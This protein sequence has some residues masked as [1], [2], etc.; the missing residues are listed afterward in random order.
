MRTGDG[1]ALLLSRRWIE[2]IVI[3]FL[4][5]F[6][7]T[8][9]DYVQDIS[10]DDDGYYWYFHSFFAE[11]F[12]QTGQNIDLYDNA[13]FTGSEIAMF[14]AAMNRARDTALEQPE[15]WEVHVGNETAPVSRARRFDLL[16][17][18][19]EH[20]AHLDFRVHFGP[21]CLPPCTQMGEYIQTR[22]RIR[23]ESLAMPQ[24]RTQSPRL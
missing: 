5:G 11:L 18:L 21:L 17:V 20:S 7:W 14:E 23:L 8:S 19:P 13:A 2:G 15:C 1:L 12:R 4:T 10:L 6:D 9:V 16:R 24:H 3:G 22:S